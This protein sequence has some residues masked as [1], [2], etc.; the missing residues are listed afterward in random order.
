MDMD[1]MRFNENGLIPVVVQDS[2]TGEVLM[3]AWA[4][5]LSLEETFRTGFMTFFSR[6]RN[7]IWKKGET[8]GNTMKL[9]EMRIDCDGDTLLALVEPA[10]PACHTGERTCFFRTVFGR[11]RGDISFV[12]RLFRLL[13]ERAGTDPET[14]YTA[15][16]LKNGAT[17]IGQKIGEEGVETALALALNDTREFVF[18]AADL[19]YH[20]MVGF[21]S[22]GV[23]LESLWEELESRH[24]KKQ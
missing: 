16:L 13:G 24:G 20:L 11:S 18:E 5:M 17:R 12:G 23:P 22:I 21:V 9:V 6:S 14:S 1:A 8:S 4:S 15:R 3:M 10:G 7:R 2:A 19:V